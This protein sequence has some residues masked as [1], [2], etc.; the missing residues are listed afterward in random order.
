MSSV[1]G[2]EASNSF[3]WTSELKEGAVGE[4]LKRS[5]SGA[6]GCSVGRLHRSV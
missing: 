2:L 1:Q 3:A 5:S 4:S 6:I